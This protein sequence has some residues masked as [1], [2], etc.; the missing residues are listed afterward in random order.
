MGPASTTF[1]EPAAPLDPGALDAGDDPPLATPEPDTDTPLAGLEPAVDEP[2]DT[3]IPLLA[4]GDPL[5]EPTCDPVPDPDPSL[6]WPH[7]AE[8]STT[9]SALTRDEKRSSPWEYSTSSR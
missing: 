6:P 4:E 1:S 5:A 9:R 7:A 3:F 2:L 8:A